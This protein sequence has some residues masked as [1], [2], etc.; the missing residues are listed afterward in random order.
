MAALLER[1]AYLVALGEHLAAATAGDGRLFMVGGEAGSARR[2]SFAGSR[3]RSS[4]GS[5]KG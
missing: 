1:D 2:R 4:S 5:A 3:T